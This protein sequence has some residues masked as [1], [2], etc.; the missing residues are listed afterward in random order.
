MECD[1]P[2]YS[3]AK[4]HLTRYPFHPPHNEIDEARHLGWRY[5]VHRRTV[6]PI[7]RLMVSRVLQKRSHATSVGRPYWM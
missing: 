6:Q 4:Q 5:V 2:V 3:A 7:Q 1:V